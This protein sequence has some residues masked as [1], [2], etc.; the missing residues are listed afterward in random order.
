MPFAPCSPIAN[1]AG[2]LDRVAAAGRLSEPPRATASD[3]R[4]RQR[5][6]RGALGA[7]ARP[8]R[9]SLG[10]AGRW[11]GSARW[12]SPGSCFS[13]ADLRADRRRHA[14]AQPGGDRA[15]AMVAAAGVRAGLR[16]HPA[17]GF[18]QLPVRAGA[19]DLRVGAVAFG[20]E[21]RRRMARRLWRSSMLV[22]MAC[23]FSHIAALGVYALAIIGL[24]NCCRQSPRCEAGALPRSSGTKLTAVRRA[25]R[26]RRSCSCSGQPPSAGGQSIL[27]RSARKT[28]SLCSASLTI[29]AGRSTSSVLCCSCRRCS[30]VLGW[31]RRWLADRAAAQDAVLAM[32]VRRAYLLLP[33]QMLL[34]ASGVDR[35]LPEWR[36]FSC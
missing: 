33:S 3:R 23:F 24:E 35:R 13:S 11:R 30:A 22:A 5:V 1:D 4:G 27:R 18:S 10:R 29:T 21:G 6:L 16:P 2:V 31:R 9:P 26:R 12:T 34:R 8:S 25:V 14:V 36:C 17:V 19:R 7:A 28:D 15:L 32:P 20:L